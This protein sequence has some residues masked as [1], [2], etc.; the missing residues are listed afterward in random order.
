MAHM[1]L[2]ALPITLEF[3]DNMDCDLL[4][5]ETVGISKFKVRRKMFV[6]FL[7]EIGAL[8]ITTRKNRFINL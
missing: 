8:M 4:K 6:L 1:R 2:W 5:R 7:I 3:M